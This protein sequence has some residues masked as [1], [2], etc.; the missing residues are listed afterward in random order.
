MPALPPE[1]TLFPAFGRDYK[2]KA[3]IIADLEAGKD[4]IFD[5]PAHEPHPSDG[6]PINLEQLRV[7]GAVRLQIRYKKKRSSAFFNVAD[8]ISR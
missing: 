8:L 7:D 4:F 6:K 3:A 1:V 2:G 5:A